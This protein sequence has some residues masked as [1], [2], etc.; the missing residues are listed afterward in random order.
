MGIQFEIFSYNK[1]FP[2]DQPITVKQ[3]RVWGNKNIFKVGI[4]DLELQ[5][6]ANYVHNFSF[7]YYL[8]IIGFLIEFCCLRTS[9]VYIS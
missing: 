6:K 2:T 4:M 7:T 1:K 3:G 5:M 9:H 8:S